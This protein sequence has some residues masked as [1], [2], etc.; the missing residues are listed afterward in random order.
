MKDISER[1]I[2]FISQRERLRAEEDIIGEPKKVKE[3][4]SQYQR[5]ADQLLVSDLPEEFLTRVADR[6]MARESWMVSP[7]SKAK[8]E[9]EKFYITHILKESN[10][11][12]SQ[13]SRKAQM[14]RQNLQQKIRKYG[15][16]PE[17]EREEK[18]EN[19]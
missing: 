3:A 2:D 13:A 18:K 4:L 11:N 6:R 15:I 14:F 19:S 12:I 1:V 17:E 9:F 5:L 7:F 10:W 16:K 8:E